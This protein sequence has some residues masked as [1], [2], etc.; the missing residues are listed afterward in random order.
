MRGGRR[1][2]EGRWARTAFARHRQ[3][4]LVA[5]TDGE[6]A[7]SEAPLVHRPN[8]LVAGP[9]MA[10]VAGRQRP[11]QGQPHGGPTVE[12][13][14]LR[15]RAHPQPTAE[16]NSFDVIDVTCCYS[17]CF[18]TMSFDLEFVMGI[19]RI[20]LSILALAT[21]LA[22]KFHPDANKHNPAAK[23][24]FQEIREAYETL[25]DTDKRAQY[26]KELSGDTRQRRYSSF[27]SNG[28]NSQNHGPFS[29]TF[30]NI[31]SEIFEDDRETFAPDVELLLSF[32]EAAKGCTKSLYLVLMYHVIHAWTSN[33]K[34]RVCTTCGGTGR[35][36][37]IPFTSR[38][39]ACKDWVVLLRLG[40]NACKDHCPTCAGSGV[41][42]HT[43][44]VDVSIPA[45]RMLTFIQGIQFECQ[46]PG[47]S[48]QRGVQP[49]NL[50][51]KLKVA[52]DPIFSRD[53]ADIYVDSNI[54]FTQAILGGKV[55]VPTLLGKM[56][57]K[58]PKGVQPGQLL[59]LRG[60][61]LP[62]RLGFVDHGDQYVRFC[63]KFPLE[64]PPEVPLEEFAKEEEIIERN[65]YEETK[66]LD[67]RL[68]T[69]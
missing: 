16:T 36:T 56:D 14:V 4:P 67:E 35:V 49:G 47:N 15:R 32:S 30:Y 51:I 9:D 63:V 41:V 31:F 62:K 26:D 18:L 54:S 19:L 17:C 43:K 46:R 28:F 61:G 45:G 60:R 64:R 42:K 38:C 8:L 12:L 11:H 22:K 33:A 52:K 50:F 57:V 27:D 37:V 68:S 13:A 39:S 1:R 23:R 44:N 53:G 21:A 58:I 59:V 25:R 6:S 5:A 69:G 40:Y 65:A 29:D 48:G 55:Q 3:P 24:K 20:C 66:W 10:M 34:P 7:S 2:E